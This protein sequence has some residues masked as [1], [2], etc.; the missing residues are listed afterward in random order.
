MARNLAVATLALALSLAT[1]A[2]AD[3]A[4]SISGIGAIRSGTGTSA[5]ALGTNVGWGF[6]AEWQPFGTSSRVSWGV[7]WSI[8]WSYL[9]DN[10]NVR[11]VDTV[12]LLELDG[13]LK[14][15]IAP[16]SVPGRNIILGAGAAMMRTDTPIPPTNSREYVGPLV[17]A[18]YEHT[19][20]GTVVL[21]FT[22]EYDVIVSNGPTMITGVMGIGAQ[23]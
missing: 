7:G 4:G 20:F 9:S 1:T 18:G 12:S 11:V 17:E 21:S 19:L 15:R 22:V 3:S 23:L 10:R 13:I 5:A 16:T 14:L 8:L 6:A 2:V